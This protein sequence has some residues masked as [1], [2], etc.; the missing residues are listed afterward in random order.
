MK[1]AAVDFGEAVASFARFAHLTLE[2][3]FLRH[4]DALRR[5]P[6]L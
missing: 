4:P 5:G 2:S 6:N 3:Y 1:K